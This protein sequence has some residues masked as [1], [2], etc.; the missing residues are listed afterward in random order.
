[1]ELQESVA[2]LEAAVQQTNGQF[3]ISQQEL[4]PALTHLD[5]VLSSELA[6][7]MPEIL[8]IL[9]NIVKITDQIESV[10]RIQRKK[11]R[12]KGGNIRDL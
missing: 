6:K 2:E 12:S 3:S 10:A 5:A 9:Q 7:I 11:R 1:M 4:E 8:D